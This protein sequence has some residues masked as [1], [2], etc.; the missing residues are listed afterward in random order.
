MPENLLADLLSHCRTR[1]PASFSNHA[2]VSQIR[3]AAFARDRTDSLFSS[4]VDSEYVDPVW[5]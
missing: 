3:F 5:I 2:A 4:D 1:L